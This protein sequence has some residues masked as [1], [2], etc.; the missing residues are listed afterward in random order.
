MGSQTAILAEKS[1]TGS[2][3]LKSAQV[4]NMAAN[5]V[6]HCRCKKGQL[7]LNGTEFTHIL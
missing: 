6:Q 3:A 1:E 2:G 4:Q 7:Q 5:V